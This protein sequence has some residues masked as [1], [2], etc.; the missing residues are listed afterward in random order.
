MMPTGK[1]VL[2][3]AMLALGVTGLV[4]CWA[5]W[6]STPGT[7]PLAA[8]LSMFWSVTW[9]SAAVLAFRGSRLAPAAFAG[10]ILLLLPLAFL[11]MPGA[12]IALILPFVLTAIVGLAGC[13]YLRRAPHAAVAG[14]RGE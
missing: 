5:Y 11:I 14:R 4:A 3:T 8:L 12:G 7:S 10:A 9:L 1:R 2:A 13:R 6:P